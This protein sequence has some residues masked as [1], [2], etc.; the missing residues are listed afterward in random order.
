[1]N[2]SIEPH[3]SSTGIIFVSGAGLNGWIWQEVAAAVSEPYV[4]ADYTALFTSSQSQPTLQDYVDA[5]YA[6]A[7]SLNTQKVLVVAH[8]AGGVVGV[9]LLKKLGDKAAGIVAVCA[10]IPKPGSS[11]ISTLPVPQKFIMPLILKI[12]G[13]KPPESQIRSGLGGGL[14]TEV[15]DKLVADFRKESVHLYT[16]KTSTQPLPSVPAFYLKTTNDKEFT[17]AMQ[18]AMASNLQAR[19]IVTVEAGHMPMLSQPA[20]IAESIAELLTS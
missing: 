4:F 3:T 13:T 19:K 14:S 20:V 16:D 12:A 8:S 18:N 7:L 17:A 6:Q 9:E 15:V 10:S 1:M 2:Q 5:A 11:Y